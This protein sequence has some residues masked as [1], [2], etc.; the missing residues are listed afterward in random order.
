MR[1][2]L[3][4]KWSFLKTQKISIFLQIVTWKHWSC[5]SIRRVNI[6]VKSVTM[7]MDM[8]FIVESTARGGWNKMPQWQNKTKRRLKLIIY[9]IMLF[10]FAKRF[11]IVCLFSIFPVISNY[12][13]FRKN[14]I[15]KL[16]I[17]NGWKKGN[18]QT[19]PNCFKN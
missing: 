13:F 12:H 1:I 19:M 17:S 5:W 10:K 9:N 18:R 4:A 8:R 16:I 14:S 15:L 11:D 7:D 6:R 2:R 3:C